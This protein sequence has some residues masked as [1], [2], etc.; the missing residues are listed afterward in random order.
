MREKKRTGMLAFVLQNE[1][2]SF[3]NTFTWKL[4]Q[5]DHTYENEGWVRMLNMVD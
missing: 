3:Q 1:N 4:K 5:E 2:Q